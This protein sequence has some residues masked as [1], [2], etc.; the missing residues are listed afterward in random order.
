[1]QA[2]TFTRTLLVSAAFAVSSSAMAQATDKGSTAASKQS[3]TKAA[4]PATATKRLDFRAERQHQGNG[5]TAGGA[6]RR[7]ADPR[8]GR[9][10]LRPLGR[11]RRL[12]RDGRGP[13][14]PGD[15]R[16][17]GSCCPEPGDPA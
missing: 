3:T 11:E 1:M 16:R 7:H 8:Q 6:G 2:R 12:T 9:L 17:L 5:D 13:F 14:P 15:G 10:A 4:K